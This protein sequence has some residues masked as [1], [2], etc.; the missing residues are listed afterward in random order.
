MDYDLGRAHGKVVIT[1]DT[2][3]A[4]RAM[5]DYERATKGAT[6]AAD[7][8]G[9]IEQELTERRRLA[10]EAAI[11]RK[12]AEAEYK[13][14]MADSTATA[15]QQIE[16]EQRRN[17]AMG[18]HMQAARRAADA[19]RALSASIAGNKQAVDKFLLSLDRSSV[20][21]GRHTNRMRSMRNEADKL[22]DS[23]R[24]LSRTMASV[25]AT[26]G[27]GLAITGGIGAAGGLGALLGAGGIQGAMVGLSGLASVIAQFSGS[28]LLV[29]AAV[30]G[31]VASIGTLT[32]AF[33]GVGD[34]LKSMDDPKKFVE[35]LGKLGP[36]TK[37]FVLQ[38]YQ[39]R[40]VFRGFKQTIQDGLFAPLIK[41]IDPL[42][43]Q[44]LPT[45]MDGLRSVAN[46]FGELGAGFAQFL[47]AP[48]TV[49][50]ISIFLNNMAT[51]L[52][53]MLPGMQAFSEAFRTLSV[54]G[55]SFFPQLANSF[56]SLATKF[57]AWIEKVNASGQLQEWIQNGINAFGQLA[58]TVR[59][60]GIAFH[61]V[62]QAATGGTGGA[63]Q[64]IENLAGKFRAWTESVE[65]NQSLANF[66]SK[67]R[68]ATDALMPVLKVV[69]KA[70]ASTLG[71][72]TDAGIGMQSGLLSFFTSLG[73]ALKVFGETMKSSG[74]QINELLKVVG[75]T[76]LE[77]VKAVGPQ[78]P[79]LFQS[80]GEILKTLA[81]IL[82]TVVTAVTNFLASLSP[83]QMKGLLI[84]VGVLGTLG[85]ILPPLAAGITAITTVIGAFSAVMGVVS[86]PVLA[87]VAALAALVAIGVLV[88]LNWD[89]IKEKAGQLWERMKEFGAW[90][91]DTFIPTVQKRGAAI[92]EAR[93][94]SSAASAASA[95]IDHMRN[96]VQGTPDGDWV[97]MGVVS[98]GSY[99][100]PEGLIS[101][102]PCTC[103]DG[104]W[105]IVQG[106][107]ID[108]V[109]RP[110]IEASV[111]ELA[112]E[113][114]A[115]KELGLI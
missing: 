112:E 34:A 10:T 78:L 94:A 27:K 49:E 77:I 105:S 85:A 104:R 6:K 87:V 20:S 59:D 9:R 32:L 5:G 42:V 23:M 99:G 101:G 115:V 25:F 82:V 46:A 43:R 61:N 65:G 18:D 97:S 41:E 35:S 95:A 68:E 88:Y 90:I 89:T 36:A 31:A 76:L 91:A 67:V 93:G 86:L 63:L 80:F 1:A 28:L 37:E 81:P 100:V 39:F 17:K 19:E 74:P 48:E 106:I 55:S 83:D 109:S 30:G 2:R 108:D 60:F 16:A 4:T 79:A 3:D 103:A 45:L 58:R 70:I 52:K 40:D 102:F 75:T 92:I 54:V 57:G 84:A 29:P 26:M 62:F 111:A 15:E 56:N 64:W 66:F 24:G 114:D 14:V 98:D 22:A 7:D 71:S 38:I 13:R 8:Q 47:R 51:A 33:Q 53:A 110:R 12:E 113:R 96:W 107:E 69:G 44:L 11:R 50:A 21:L 72:L 73:E